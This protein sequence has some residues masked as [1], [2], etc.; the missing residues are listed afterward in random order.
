MEN[1]NGK[2]VVI[3][4]GSQ[5]VG[6]ALA[7]RFAHSGAKLLLAARGKKKLDVLAEELRPFTDVHVMAMDVCDVDACV[8]LLKKAEFEFG[9]VDILISNAGDHTR[10]P[11]E[12]VSVEEMGRMID[13]N[14]RAPIVLSRLALPYLR[15]SSGGAAIV[16]VGSLAGRVPVKNA[17]TYSAGKA[18][19]RAF[20]FALAEELRGEDIKLAVVSPGP[21]DTG[22]IMANLDVVADI[23]FSQPIC[24]AEEVAEEVVKLCL[25]NRRERSI[26]PISG[27]LTMVS[28]LF[29]SIGRLLQPL[30]EKRGRKVKRQLKAERAAKERGGTS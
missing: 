10:G 4:G 9:G 23:I 30:L 13:V 22:F 17:A 27:A 2:V 29:P 14:L 16:N 28:Y 20:T 15:K 3:T 7:R 6:A 21:I 12:N 1:F 24:T 8:N 11:V 18:G 25:N 26:P 19:L 5:G